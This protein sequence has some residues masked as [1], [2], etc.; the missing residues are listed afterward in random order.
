MI[1]VNLN[2]I[3]KTWGNGCNGPLTSALRGGEVSSSRRQ[4][5]DE[6]AVGQIKDWR[7]DVKGTSH[8]LILDTYTILA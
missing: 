3:I 4:Y 2:H 1:K 7:E 8:A 6:M 5:S